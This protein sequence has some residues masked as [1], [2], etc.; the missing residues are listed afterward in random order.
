[1]THKFCLLAL[2]LLGLAVACSKEASVSVETGKSGS[3]TRFAVHNGYMYALNPNEV[4]T[5]SLT[6][7]DHPQ[8]VHR[9][10]TDYGL[11][12]IVVYEGRIYLGSRTAL[13]ILDIGNPAAPTIISQADRPEALFR[14][15][16]P[17]VVEGSYAYSTVKIIQNICGNVSAFSA[18]LTYNVG[19]PENPVN[20]S[21]TDMNLPNGLGVRDGYLFVCDEGDDL[22]AVYDLTD[23]ARPLRQSSLDVAITDPV[24]LIIDNQRMIVSTKTDFQIFDISQ[25]PLV[26]RV[27]SIAK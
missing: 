25:L 9:L 26:T 7:P 27:G 2:L 12:T 20:T 23:P 8:L 13:Y 21:R 18:L 19:D 22:L 16:D 6:D 14:G 5:Y 24:D 11:E 15:C 1:M 3:I 10:S 17:V 4:L